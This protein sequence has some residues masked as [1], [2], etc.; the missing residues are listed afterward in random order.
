[1]CD[2]EA[3]AARVQRF[4]VSYYFRDKKKKIP[5]TILISF[6]DNIYD[7]CLYKSLLLPDEDG[8][9]KHQWEG[10]ENDMMNVLQWNYLNSS[11]WEWLDNATV[12]N[13]FVA[14]ELTASFEF[15]LDFYQFIERH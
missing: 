7:A 10:I 6:P 14:T 13:L 9:I 2:H 5:R 15:D 11:I 8:G 1:M 12:H 4:L 3:Y